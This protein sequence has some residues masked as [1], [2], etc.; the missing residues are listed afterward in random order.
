MRNEKDTKISDEQVRYI[1]DLARLELSA[2][3]VSR[4]SKELGKII[5][6]IGILNEINTAG[7][8]PMY[9]SLGGF[10]RYRE[11]GLKPS[12]PRDSLLKEAPRHDDESIL[13]PVVISAG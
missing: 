10:S 3:E 13:V 2:E 8:E 7:V 6:Y 5:H 4:L 12:M 11:D 1:A 9:S